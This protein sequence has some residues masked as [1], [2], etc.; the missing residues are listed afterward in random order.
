MLLEQG[1]WEMGGHAA[2]GGVP[3]HG[4]VPVPEAAQTDLPGTVN[5]LH[6]DGDA[7]A[8]HVVHGP[9]EVADGVGGPGLPGDLQHTGRQGAELVRGQLVLGLVKGHVAVDADAPE[10]DVHA[11]QGLNGPPHVLR[12]FR[13]GKYPLAL[14]HH[15][16]GPDL[17][18][19]R[20]VH[21][22]PEAEAVVL[23]DP[24]L[25]IG[26][27]L[28]HVQEPDVFQADVLAVDHLHKIGILSNGADGADEDGLLSQCVLP[29]DLVGHLPGH[30]LKHGG[31]VRHDGNGQLRR[32]QELLPV[33]VVIFVTHHVPSFTFPALGSRYSL[34]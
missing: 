7:P 32:G 33:V 4:P 22:A 28:V 17:R 5:F 14:G 12:V 11:A 15:Q 3:G 8:G 18:V 13:I 6:A 2:V 27:V 29:P 25:P 16:I 26:E 31:V 30:G 9:V 10:A 23:A 19:D 20:P 21:E 24:L 34:P 1:H